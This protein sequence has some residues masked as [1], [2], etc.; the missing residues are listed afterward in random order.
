MRHVR[1]GLRL[2]TAGVGLNE[3]SRAAPDD[4]FRET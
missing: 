2:M 1:E 3:Q 4:G